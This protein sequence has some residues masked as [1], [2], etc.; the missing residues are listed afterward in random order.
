MGAVI[1]IKSPI[2]TKEAL[3]EM[4]ASGPMLGLIFAIPITLV[5]LSLSGPAGGIALPT[6]FLFSLM[7]FATSGSFSVAVTSHPLAFAGWIG[8]LV[9]WL[10]LIPA[11]QLDGGHIARGLL[12][13]RHH[14]ML[15]RILGFTLIVVG[16]M[17]GGLI[18]M[19][20]GMF[21][22]ILFGAPHTGA[23]NDVSRLS[24]R[25]KILAAAALIVFVLCIPIPL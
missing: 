24:R 9:T 12:S 22:L 20:W 10:N 6:P 4:G 21:I 5:G 16:F 8:L 17:T 19:V 11:G 1:K 7:G 14:Y 25:Q 13:V 3:V 18:F 23:L 15:T 2:P